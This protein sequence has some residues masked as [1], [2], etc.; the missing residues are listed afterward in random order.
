MPEQRYEGAFARALRALDSDDESFRSLLLN[1]VGL[2]LSE[3]CS[4]WQRP[5][6]QAA[7]DRFFDSTVVGYFFA[8]SGD[9]TRQIF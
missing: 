6:Q 5:W 8:G 4:Q 1:P 2:P 3:I 9:E 7:D